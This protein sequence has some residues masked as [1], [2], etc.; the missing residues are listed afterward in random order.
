MAKIIGA[1]NP[2]NAPQHPSSQSDGG[3]SAF[4][5][6]AMVAADTPRRVTSYQG[7]SQHRDTS[8]SSSLRSVAGRYRPR[9]CRALGRPEP[10]IPQAQQECSSILGH[11]SGPKI[12]TL[13][14]RVAMGV[15][16]MQASNCANLLLRE[17]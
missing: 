4:A 12:P 3:G 1:V 16:Q 2:A 7:R 8:P 11:Q 15:A 6:S 9:I 10:A 17:I 14:E 5:V 13:V